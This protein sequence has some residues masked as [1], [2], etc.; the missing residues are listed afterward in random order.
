MAKRPRSLGSL[1]PLSRLCSSR[2]LPSLSRLWVLMLGMCLLPLRASDCGNGPGVLEFPS[3][4]PRACSHCLKKR[5]AANPSPMNQD[6]VS[7]SKG[8]YPSS[9]T[10][11]KET[12]PPQTHP[13]CQ[14]L[15]RNFPSPEIC[16]SS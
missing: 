16:Q 13:G 12:P 3:V 15:F 8:S 7:L 14:N 9:G 1:A 5:G 10:K 4:W 6:Y 2:E 11:E